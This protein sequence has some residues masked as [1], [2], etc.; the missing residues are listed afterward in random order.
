PDSRVKC[1]VYELRRKLLALYQHLFGVD[2][3]KARE[4]VHRIIHTDPKRGY[5]LTISPD[6]IRLDL[7][8]R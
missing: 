4:A 6:N 1:L 3:T 5:R 2:A 7:S 8:K